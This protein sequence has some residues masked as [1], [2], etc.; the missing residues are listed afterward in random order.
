[1]ASIQPIE[2]AFPVSC[3][4]TKWSSYRVRKISAISKM[5]FKKKGEIQKYRGKSHFQFQIQL[6]SSSSHWNAVC[7]RSFTFGFAGKG[8]RETQHQGRVFT[9]VFTTHAQFWNWALYC[10]SSPRKTGKPIGEGWISAVI[11][12]IQ[13]PFLVHN[14]AILVLPQN[15]L[16]LTK[17]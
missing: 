5:K 4:L 11:A 14:W 2:S 3:T 7:M 16:M 15:Q 10:S 17:A 13:I 1:M 8:S 6:L 9:C 12:S